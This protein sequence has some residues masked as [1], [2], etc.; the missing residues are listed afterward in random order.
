MT[1]CS[2][3]RFSFVDSLD[4]VNKLYQDAKNHKLAILNEPKTIGL[5]TRGF[6]VLDPDGIEVEF[7]YHP[8]MWSVNNKLRSKT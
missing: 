2:R 5:G 8:P 4:T 6:S 7:T 3:R 1:N